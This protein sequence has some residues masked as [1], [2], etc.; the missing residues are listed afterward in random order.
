M[1]AEIKHR[2]I[3]EWMKIFSDIYSEADKERNPEQIWIAIMAHASSIGESIRTVSF[4]KLVDFAAHTF[5][6]LVS[7]TNKCNTMENDVFSLK[8]TFCGTVSLKYPFVCG[9]CYE[10]TCICDAAKMDKKDNKSAEYKK[11]LGIRKDILKSY[12]DY[13][14]DTCLN[15]FNTIYGGRIHI[16]TLENI[17]F[18][19]LEEVGEAAVAVRSLSQLKNIALDPSTGIDESFLKQ[20]STIEGIVDSYERYLKKPI[21]YESRD[22]EMLK[23]RLVDAKM[24]L[25]IEI[26]DTYSWFCG[27]I[28]KLASIM[29]TILNN[30]GK[31][32]PDLDL[33]KK[34][35]ELYINTKNEPHCPTCKSKPCKCVFFNTSPKV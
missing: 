14:I 23:S 18:H 28:N 17:G 6:W 1:S 16:Q 25:I 9:H 30:P 13:S 22:P 32:L 20:I 35:G 10:R 5:C 33:E 29:E 3:S 34:L 21:E 27:I 12:E 7:F 2:P 4:E 19:F 31:S 15:M 8:E 11:L 24:S 26:G